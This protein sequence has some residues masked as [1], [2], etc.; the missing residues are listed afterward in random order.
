MAPTKYLDINTNN[1]PSYETIYPLTA[2]L[3]NKALRNIIHSILK[4]IPDLPEWLDDNFIKDHNWLSWKDSI[5][6]IHN[7]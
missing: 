7:N 6:S 1:I 4:N 2:G 5:N 3:S